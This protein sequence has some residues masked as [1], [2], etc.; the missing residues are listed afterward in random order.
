M[1]VADEVKIGEGGDVISLTFCDLP[2]TKEKLQVLS[3][4]LK[5]IYV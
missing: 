4:A 3:R 2:T 5:G 1:N